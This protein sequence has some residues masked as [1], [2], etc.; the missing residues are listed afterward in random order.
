[1]DNEKEVFNNGEDRIIKINGKFFWQTRGTPDKFGPF[2]TLRDCKV[3]AELPVRSAKAPTSRRKKL[4]ATV[5]PVTMETIRTL[6]RPGDGLGQTIDRA[7]EA[8]KKEEKKS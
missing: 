8:L 1:M 7:I 6:T 4:T 5:S 3:D 2:D